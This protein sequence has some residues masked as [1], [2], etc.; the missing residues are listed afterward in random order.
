[1]PRTDIAAFFTHISQRQRTHDL[2]DVFRIKHA[3]RGR[4]ASVGALSERGSDW[5]GA[6]SPSATEQGTHVPGVDSVLPARSLG[7]QKKSKNTPKTTQDMAVAWPAGGAAHIPDGTDM[8]EGPGPQC[9]KAKKSK[10]T[11][12]VTKAKTKKKKSQT[13]LNANLIQAATSHTDSAVTDGI[14]DL[15]TVPPR[16]RPKPK[17]KAK[18]PPN[19]PLPNLSDHHAPVTP[20]TD[21]VVTD[22][23]ADLSTV[24]PRPRPKPKPKGKKPT[25]PPL[26]N[27]PDHH[28]PVTPVP[29]PGD[30]SGVGHSADSAAAVGAVSPP[31]LEGTPQTPIANGNIIVDDL[32]DPALCGVRTSSHHIS[33][34]PQVNTADN[35]ALIEA[36][37]YMATGK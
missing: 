15:S 5:D 23:I 27:L 1:M 9:L 17:P 36:R 13:T 25:N 31:V 20:V 37:K 26:P 3:H 32:I 24:P 35:L 28:P 12:K 19:P 18:K 22:G 4:K 8:L 16:P 7:K 30:R 2:P 34:R 10:V 21:S 11:L 33:K 29:S 14:G 6:M